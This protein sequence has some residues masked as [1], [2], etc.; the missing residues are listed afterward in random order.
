MNPWTTLVDKPVA[1]K[2]SSP[3]GTRYLMGDEDQPTPAKSY[4]ARGG[5][6]TANP[7]YPVIEN[8]WDLT[9]QQCEALRLIA[10]GLTN[11]KAAKQMGV[12]VKTFEAHLRLGRKNM[13]TDSRV[14]AAVLWDRFT[15]G[16]GE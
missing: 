10:A 1:P 11:P 6:T 15:G 4:Y 5:N 12:G 14:R 9:P 2:L 13:G 7:V 3:Q 16:R 8:P